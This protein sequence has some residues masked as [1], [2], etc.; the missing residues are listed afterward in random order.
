MKKILSNKLVLL[1]F[2]TLFLSACKIVIKGDGTDVGSNNNDTTSCAG[3]ATGVKWVALLTKDC[4]NLSDYNL[5]A[6]PGDPTANPNSGGVPYDLSTALFS[7]YAT[8]Y[9]FIFVPEGEQVQYSENEAFGFPLGTVI[10]KTFAMPENTAFRDGDETLLETRLLIL[11]E[12]GWKAR[13]YYWSSERDAEL[14]VAGKTLVNTTT[15]H[16]GADL[17]FTYQVPS[18]TQCTACHQV[19]PLVNPGPERQPVFLP[20]GPKARYLNKDYDYDGTIENQLTHWRDLGILAGLPA[21]PELIPQAPVFNDLTDVSALNSVELMESA[22]AYLDINCAHCHRAGLELPDN[23]GGA[24]GGTGLNVEY[25]RIYGDNPAKF[26]ACKEPVAGGHEDYVYDLVPQDSE[27][28]YLLFRMETNEE[29][30]RMPELGRAIVHEEGAAL[31]RAWINSL[32]AESCSP[33]L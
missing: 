33:A 20:I 1:L 12:E 27:D 4:P 23:Y 26:G 28:S 32:P 13:P 18:V 14:A 10:V 30:Q 6:D 8:K 15:N 9:R 11:R 16:N 24:A 2:A 3:D 29:R 22:K 25:Q 5:F 31:I 21:V 19:L 7:D 17:S